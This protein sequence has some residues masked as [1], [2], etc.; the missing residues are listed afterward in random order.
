MGSNCTTP[1]TRGRGRGEQGSVMVGRYLEGMA[2]GPSLSEPTHKLFV[3]S[4]SLCSWTLNIAVVVSSPK[5]PQGW[6]CSE[7]AGS[8]MLRNKGQHAAQTAQVGAGPSAEAPASRSAAHHPTGPQGLT[9]GPLCSCFS[10]SDSM[11]EGFLRMAESTPP[12]FLTSAATEVLKGLAMEGVE[13]LVSCFIG[14]FHIGLC[15]SFKLCFLRTEGHWPWCGGDERWGPWGCRGTGWAPN[16][17]LPGT[18]DPVCV[19]EW[20]VHVCM[21]APVCVCVCVCVCVYVC[22]CECERGHMGRVGEWTG[23]F[24]VNTRM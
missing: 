5:G 20:Q 24:K 14:I 16:V 19:C 13:N 10:P 2:G 21:C 17:L 9:A 12:A 22:M 15:V 3:K 1:W 7:W 6:V 18:R 23:G 4:S 8:G 11:A